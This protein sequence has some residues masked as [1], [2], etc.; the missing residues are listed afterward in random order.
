[1]FF[2]RTI[3]LKK[4]WTKEQFNPSTQKSIE[5]SIS[6]LHG[7]SISESYHTL[8]AAHPIIEKLTDQTQIE[9]IGPK[10]II[11]LS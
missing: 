7:P 4:A 3:K 2:Y 9:I 11:R 10:M 6:E 5:P 8:Y 1:M